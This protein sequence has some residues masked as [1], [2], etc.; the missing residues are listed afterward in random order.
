VW[1]G[2][3]W[4]AATLPLVGLGFGSD[5]DAWSLGRTAE[6]IWA[7][8]AYIRSR[9]PGFPLYEIAIAPL[10]AA[11]GWIATNLLSVASGCI[12]LALIARLS[13]RGGLRHGA[14]TA[15]TLLLLPIVVKN[16]SSTMD[17][18]P[19]LAVLVGAY[20]AWH[21]RRL[22][23][24]GVLV[25]FACGLRPTNGL[26]ILPASLSI[27]VERRQPQLVL[28][29]IGTALAV[30]TVAF[31]PALG[32][33]P[34]GVPRHIPWLPGAKV[35]MQLFGIAQ[36]PIL[37]GLMA[38]ARRSAPRNPS[39][40]PFDVFHATNAAAFGLAF[41]AH[42][43]G[44]EYLLPVALS[45]VLWLD[46]C[47]SRPV[48]AA[49]CAVALSYHLVAVDITGSR[50]GMRPLQVHLTTGYT[51]RDV[52]DR[53]F[54]LWLREA[55]ESWPGREP[56]VLLEL[57]V[58]PFAADRHWTYDAEFDVFRRAG[59]QMAVAQMV[60]DPGEVRRLRDGGFRVVAWREREWL[61]LRP[62][63][64]AVRHLVVFE[65]DLGV[66]LEEPQ[67]GYPLE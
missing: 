62:P 5:A 46:R 44:S 24:C 51:V 39:S 58:Q 28:L 50:G 30:G 2:A 43:G 37:I 15:G 6:L 22:V 38:L 49:A 67:R 18:L 48:M 65:D 34:F 41:L 16:G 1:L 17:F 55:V 33:N 29:L 42:P 52:A 56:T 12:L 26:F 27:W 11:G 60:D 59:T 31:W 63:L 64:D 23:L 25:G 47:A 35:G 19:S 21:E 4:L 3:L 61:F 7:H 20:V 57:Q 8:R 66:L 36:T 54:K 45:V 10:A 40:L 9:Q 32:L 53:R 13:R 14:L